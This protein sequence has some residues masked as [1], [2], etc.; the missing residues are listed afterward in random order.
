MTYKIEF[1]K[2]AVILE[3]C[4]KK[5]EHLSILD[6][7]FDHGLSVQAGC[8]SGYCGTCQ[9]KLISG[10]IKHFYEPPPVAADSGSILLCSCYPA[11]DIVIDK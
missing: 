8:R 6:L 3:Y 2:S 4:T 7:A 11:S 1:L 10:S 5:H 9:A